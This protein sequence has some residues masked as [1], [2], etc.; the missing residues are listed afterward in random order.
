VEPNPETLVHL[1]ENI[2]LSRANVTVAPF[3]C[4][5]QETTL[6]LYGSAGENTGMSS[7]AKSNAESEGPLGHKFKVRARPLDDLVR[8]AGLTRLDALKIDVEGAELQ[9]LRG[10]KETLSRFSPLLVIEVVDS[11]LRQIG[12]SEAELRAHL[13]ALGYRVR[14]SFDQ[15]VVFTR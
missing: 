9:V 7:L 5:D 11:Q 13:T 4:S 2:A 10:A 6:E 12:T 8:E 15:N 14:Q 1:R 3:A